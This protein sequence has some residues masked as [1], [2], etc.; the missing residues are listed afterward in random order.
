MFALRPIH[1][2]SKTVVFLKECLLGAIWLVWLHG[3][4]SKPCHALQERTVGLGR[5][6]RADG[7]QILH[8]SRRT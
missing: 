6:R 2:P 1:G 7:P 3:R 4:P 5:A 8:K